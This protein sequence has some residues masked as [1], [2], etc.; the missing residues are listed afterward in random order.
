MKFLQ[1]YDKLF[2]A[3][4]QSIIDGAKDPNLTSGGYKSKEEVFSK[5]TKDGDLPR[6][7]FS[8]R[9][10]KVIETMEQNDNYIAFEMMWMS[11]PTSKYFNG[12][13]ITDIDISPVPYSFQVTVRGKKFDM[14][15]GKFLRYYWP[16]IF[17]ESEIK[18]FITLYHDL[19]GS[20]LP[21]TT[22]SGIKSEKII[23]EGFSFN[24]KD[25]RKT[26]LS[27]TTKTYPHFTDCRHEKEVLKF[28]P[29]DLKRDEVGNYYKIIGNE[30]PETMFTSH[31]DTADREQKITNLYSVRGRVVEEGYTFRLVKTGTGD[32]IIHTDGSSILGADDKSGVTVM[33]YMMAN[34]VPGL[35]YFFIGEERGGIGSNA[36]ST[37]YQSVDYLENIKRCV[38]FDR[39]RTT[40]V[41]THQL[42]RRCC[43]NEFGSALAQQYSGS[44]VSLSLD[45]T[46]VYTD[47]ASF[48]D[49][50]PECTNISVGYY[51]EHKGTEMQN[52]DYLDRLAKASCKVDW[53]SLPTVRKAGLNSEVYQKYKN[54][55]DEI[56]KTVFGLEIKIVGELDKVYVR[57]DIE[58]PD[59]MEVLD[60]LI[61]IQMLLG[62][63]GVIDNCQFDK[64]YIKI[65]LK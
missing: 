22:T 56:K 54:L 9:L 5:T 8:E 46:G 19:L 52:I 6:I 31:L 12:L 21:Q 13:N 23:V 39:R 11:E 45:S 55:I 3:G 36:L 64:T 34:N 48:M 43:S 50:I 57:I 28:L 14:K 2:E 20:E 35:Y 33:L 18:T 40:S 49:D 27:L 60:S 53:N 25:V 47:S 59:L 38:S 24:P 63:Y 29:S 51:N 44:G 37:I 62:K 17:N 58:E 42:G 16:N 32:E 41:I 7:K 61:Q 30:K 26:F 65:E 10:T 1:N 15:I 4:T